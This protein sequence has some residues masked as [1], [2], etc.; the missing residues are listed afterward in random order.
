MI[1]VIEFPSFLSRVD[2]SIDAEERDEFIDYIAKNPEAGRIIQGT[3]GIRKVRWGSKNKG[4][5]G[6]VRIIYYFYDEQAPIFL[7]TAYGKGEKENLTS[8]QKKQ[9]SALAQVLKS[10]CK[11]T[12]RRSHD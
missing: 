6:G 9:L 1:T 12:R 11:Y 8:E 10:E 4:K 3:G 2:K 7:L 5:S